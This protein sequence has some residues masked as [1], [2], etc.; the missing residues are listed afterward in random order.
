MAISDHLQEFHGLPVFEFPDIARKVTLPPP[1]T[2][3]WRIAIEPYGDSAET[4]PEAFARFLETVDS[5]QV[6][7]LVIGSWGESDE[8]S[9]PII[10]ALIEAKDRLR[11]LRGI[12]LGD[13]TYEENEISW[14]HQSDV[15]PLLASFP[16]LEEF[17][18]RG[19][20]QLAFPALTHTALRNLSVQA[21][22]LGAEVVQGVGASELPALETLDIWLGVSWYGGT[23]TVADLEPILSG[24]KFP[25]LTHLALR[26]SEIQDEIAAAVAGAPV[27]ARLTTLDLSMGTLGNEGA[28]ALLAGQ[29]LTHLRKLD[30][31]HH[32]IGPEMQKRL[33]AALEPAGVVLDLS[34]AEVEDEAEDPED[35]RYTAVS[36]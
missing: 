9:A 18:V 36:E 5:T 17:G 12:F 24:A 34:D 25:R 13:I 27:V 29:P 28:E 20:E 21:G 22:G 16:E 19:G 8:D 35:R 32:F 7:A 3:A 4:W 30:L 26:N 2:V 31:H 23:A 33:I 1:E 11:A 10:A 14:I 6:R 15:S